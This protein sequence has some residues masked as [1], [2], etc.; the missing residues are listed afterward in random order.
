MHAT[1]W[2]L[3]LIEVHLPLVRNECKKVGQTIHEVKK[4]LGLKYLF[5]FKFSL[6]SC[7]CL[8]DGYWKFI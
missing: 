7:D 8:Y 1:I 5:F 6:K 4:N 2:W 3:F